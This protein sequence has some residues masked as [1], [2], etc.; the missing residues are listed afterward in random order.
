MQFKIALKIIENFDRYDITIDE[1]EKNV[2][3]LYMNSNITTEQYM[4]LLEKILMIK[5]GE[6]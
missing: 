3:L 6:E 4:V 1:Y 5:G 2:N